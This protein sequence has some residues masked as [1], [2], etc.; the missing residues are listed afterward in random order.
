LAATTGGAAETFGLW[1]RQGIASAPSQSSELVVSAGRTYAFPWVEAACQQPGPGCLVVEAV[2]PDGVTIVFPRFEVWYGQPRPSGFAFR[3]VV[4]TKGTEFELYRIVLRK[5]L[6][7]AWIYAALQEVR[8]NTARLVFLRYPAWVGRNA[9]LTREIRVNLRYGVLEEIS[10]LR[11]AEPVTMMGL[12]RVDWMIPGARL[13]SVALDGRQVS[14]AYPNILHLT[15]PEGNH[16]L[17]VRIAVPPERPVEVGPV[18]EPKPMDLPREVSLAVEPAGRRGV[19]TLTAWT[20]G[21]PQEVWESSRPVSLDHPVPFAIS[22]GRL[23]V[24]YQ[25]VDPLAVQLR[26]KPSV[27]YGGRVYPITVTVES[28][29]P[30]PG[31]R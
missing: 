18:F 22:Q 8:G 23:A 6:R 30:R 5:D 12:R 2:T 25:F 14:F 26:M 9:I 28:S 13:E 1:R 31:A 16:D 3:V 11:A 19:L 17:A 20:F 21:V 15:V 29:A 4:T 7:E 24:R 10:R 27:R